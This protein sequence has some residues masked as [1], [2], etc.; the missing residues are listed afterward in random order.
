MDTEKG[1]LREHYTYKGEFQ[2][3]KYNGYGQLAE[4]KAGQIGLMYTGQFKDDKYHGRGMLKYSNGDMYEGEYQNNK[5]H[6]FKY[7][8][9]NDMIYEGTWKEED[10]ENVWGRKIYDKGCKTKYKG[11]FSASRMHGRGTFKVKV[12]HWS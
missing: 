2:N 10:S 5:R 1:A 6:G 3:G 4:Q 7:I 8:F 12:L 11:E 9:A